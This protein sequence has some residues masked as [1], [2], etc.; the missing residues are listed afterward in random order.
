MR[1]IAASVAAALAL[2]GCSVSHDKASAEAGVVRFHQLL[3]AGRYH[4]IYAGAEPEFRR[5]GSEQEEIRVLQMIHDRLGAF[6]SSQQS[7]WR[8][9]FATGG[10]IVGL[11][12][13]ARFASAAGSENFVF[14]IKSG[15]ALLVGYHVNSPVLADTAAS[16]PPSKPGESAAPPI[17]T[18]APAEPPRPA[19]AK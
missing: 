18:V 14:R 7:G 2:G 4:D 8:V 17:V 10:N 3:E 1:T 16:A 13:N 11:T 6:R 9:N 5:S 12:Y 15:G 19:G